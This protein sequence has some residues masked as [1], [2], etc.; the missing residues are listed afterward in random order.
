M[1]TYALHIRFTLQSDRLE[2][3][4]VLPQD[5]GLYICRIN[6]GPVPLVVGCLIFHGQLCNMHMYKIY[7]YMYMHNA[8]CSISA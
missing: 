4:P 3:D 1:S 2:I 8:C 7:M 6:E 5:E